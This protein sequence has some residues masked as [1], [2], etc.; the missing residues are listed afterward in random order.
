MILTGAEGL[1]KMMLLRQIAVCAAAGLDPFTYQPI[2]PRTV[3]LVDLENP[4]QI[5]RQTIRKM[6][7]SAKVKSARHDVADRVFVERRPGRSQPR[8]PY[9]RGVADEAGHP[10]PARHPDHRPALQAD[11]RQPQRRGH[12]PRLHRRPGPDPHPWQLRAA[13][14]GARR[15]RLQRR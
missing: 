14:R 8:R 11:E 13:A 1:G 10:L 2:E 7:E 12:G 6:V 9:E 15:A 4:A 5:M 3:L